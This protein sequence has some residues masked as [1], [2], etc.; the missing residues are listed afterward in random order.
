MVY[1]GSGL[2]PVSG[3][4]SD[5]EPA[6]LDPRYTVSWPRPDYEGRLMHYWPSYSTID[7]TSRAAYL[8]WLSSGRKDPSAAIGHVFL[9]F[10]G[11]ER[12]VLVDAQSSEHAKSEVDGL[13]AEVERLLGIYGG[14]GSSF[15][16]YAGSFLSV[17]RLL[18][19]PIDPA[20]LQPPRIRSWEIPLTLKIALGAFAAEGKPV[21]PE[22]AYSWVACSPEIHLRTP[23]QRCPSEFEELF[24]I[25]YAEAFTAG[26]LKVT[27][28]TPIKASYHPAS[29]SFWIT[30]A[31]DWTS[32]GP[33]P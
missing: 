10:Y 18:H 7:P 14:N 9:F 17:A 20:T 26:G 25:R 11:I 21:P 3:Y 15:S 5:V 28:K 30:P 19:R 24:K 22:W 4:R 29:S 6:L 23:A 1:F 27:N 2:R 31:V 16:G 13:L 8:H 12:R 32:R 33:G